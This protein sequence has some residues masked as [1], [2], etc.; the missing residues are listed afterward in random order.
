MKMTSRMRSPKTKS[1]AAFLLA[2][3]LVIL[4][5]FFSISLMAHD[6][7]HVGRD[8]PSKFLDEVEGMEPFLLMIQFAFFFFMP[9][10]CGIC[11]PKGI[12]QAIF[13]PALTKLSNTIKVISPPPRFSGC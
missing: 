11:T 13:V 9:V 5:G 4:I 10:V 12:S 7:G 3:W 1:M 2:L 8:C 6:C